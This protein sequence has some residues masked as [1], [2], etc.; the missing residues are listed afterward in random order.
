MMVAVAAGR[1]LRLIPEPQGLF[2]VSHGWRVALLP[3]LQMTSSRPILGFSVGTREGSGP[4]E[5]TLACWRIV[6]G[7]TF[8]SQGFSCSAAPE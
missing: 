4:P 5:V 7:L 6:K 3:F 1:T 8:H 2:S